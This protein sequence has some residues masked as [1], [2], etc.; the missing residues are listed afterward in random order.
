MRPETS[1]GSY[2]QFKSINLLNTL[3]LLTSFPVN[4]SLFCFFVRRGEKLE[5]WRKNMQVYK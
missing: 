4:L 2:G 1:P 5:L 3:T